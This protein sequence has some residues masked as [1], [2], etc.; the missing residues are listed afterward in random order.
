M[1][2]YCTVQGLVFFNF[3]NKTRREGLEEMLKVVFAVIL[4]ILPLFLKKKI[5]SVGQE[6]DQKILSHLV[7]ATEKL[8][9][10]KE[11]GRSEGER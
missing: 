3:S 5:D 11:H 8:E 6:E 2:N 7:A 9:C 1:K 4:L 10:V